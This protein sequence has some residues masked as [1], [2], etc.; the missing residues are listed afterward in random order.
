MTPRISIGGGT[1]RVR[2]SNAYGVAP[3]GDRRGAHRAARQGAGDRARL[4]PQRSTF[5]GAAG[6][7]I[8]AGAVLVSDPVELDVPAARRP[9]G[10]LLSAAGFA[11][12]RFGITGRYARQTNYISPPGDF[13]GETAMPVGK[14]TDE[15]Y[16]LCGVDVLAAPRKRAG[17]SRS[18][19]R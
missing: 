5:G 18:A 16:F 1:L 19:T 14:L 7:A 6:A 8:A 13:T 4:R 3:A 11:G 9:R 12:R 17:S 15:W 2:I 10:Q